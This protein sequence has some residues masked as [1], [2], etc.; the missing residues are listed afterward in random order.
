MENNKDLTQII[1]KF[2][3]LENRDVFSRNLYEILVGII[4]GE[5]ERVLRNENITDK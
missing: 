4:L 5:L 2:Y 1:K 3:L